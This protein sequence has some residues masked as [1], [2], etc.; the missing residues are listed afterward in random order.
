MSMYNKSKARDII[1]YFYPSKAWVVESIIKS[2][3]TPIKRS[4]A[5]DIVNKEWA[6][7]TKNANKTLKNKGA[8]AE[9]KQ[10]A[11]SVLD[12]AKAAEDKTKLTEINDIIRI[13]ND[14]TSPTYMKNNAIKRWKEIL[15]DRNRV[16]SIW[17]IARK[18]MNNKWIIWWAISSQT[19]D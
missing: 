8:T 1:E 14:N 15:W 18:L 3:S 5:K 12:D 10:Y 16:Q 2:W 9:E 13:L 6:I 17:D 11:Q 19:S 7:R 4:V